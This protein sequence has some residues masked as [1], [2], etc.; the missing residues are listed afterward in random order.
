MSNALKAALAASLENDGAV[1]ENSVVAEVLEEIVAV[2]EQEI[3][4]P[5]AVIEAAQQSTDI[6]EVLEVI[7]DN[8][9]AAVEPEADGMTQN[10]EQQ[11]VAVESAAF[12]LNMVLSSHGVRLKSDSMES[13]SVKGRAAR[14]AAIATDAAIGARENLS[15]SVEAFAT[16]VRETVQDQLKVLGKSRSAIQAA[17]AKI[18]SKS[19]ELDANGVTLNYKGIYDFLHR[20]GAPVTSL[21]DALK[22]DIKFLQDLKGSINDLSKDYTAAVS[23]ADGTS[24]EGVKKFADAISQMSWQSE[25]GKYEG[26]SLLGNG[27]VTTE[28]GDMGVYGTYVAMDI[29]YG[30]TDND[31]SRTSTGR[32][33][34]GATKGGALGGLLGGMAGAMLGGA[35][36]VPGVGLVVGGALGA[37]PGAAMGAKS[38]DYKERGSKT[39]VTNSAADLVAFLKDCLVICDM[40]S[41]LSRLVAI[42]TEDDAKARSFLKSLMATIENKGAMASV[43]INLVGS[44]AMNMANNNRTGYQT[45]HKTDKQRL[46][47]TVTALLDNAEIGYTS[48]LQV[49]ATHMLTCVQGSLAVATKVV[50]AL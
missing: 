25:M 31:G 13:D 29:D 30:T 15:A 17:I 21:K 49:M 20:G 22:E 38:A 10:E 37:A 42:G 1:D 7:A 6:A 44:I 48:M 4:D 33:L 8:A 47:E 11:S 5:Q 34:W 45:L 40:V 3:P 43:A 2:S 39:D 50:E 12:A 46:Q 9:V 35:F 41:D 36:G 14:V 24:E 18:S 32:R 19:K 16:D 27:L 23:K 26:R 28:A